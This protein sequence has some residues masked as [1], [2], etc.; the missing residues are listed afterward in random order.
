MGCLDPTSWCTNKLKVVQR[1]TYHPRASI[2][3]VQGGRGNRKATVITMR[4][5]GAMG[6]AA[7]LAQRQPDVLK[8]K[9]RYR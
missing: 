2:I 1:D 7:K 5:G 9:K 8:K 4:R 6:S 3:P